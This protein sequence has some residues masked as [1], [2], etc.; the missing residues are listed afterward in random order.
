VCWG[1]GNPANVD[2]HAVVE[3][4]RGYGE[5]WI[6]DRETEQ[7]PSQDFYSGY[8]SWLPVDEHGRP[9]HPKILWEEAREQDSQTANT[10]MTF[11][12][13]VPYNGWLGTSHDDAPEELGETS[14][15]TCFV[16][17][18][19]VPTYGCVSPTF[20]IAVPKAHGHRPFKSNAPADTDQG[21]SLQS[22]NTT[23]VNTSSCMAQTGKRQK[24]RG[25]RGIAAAAFK[26]DI[27]DIVSQTKRSVQSTSGVRRCRVFEQA[28]E[29][30]LTLELLPVTSVSLAEVRCAIATSAR[31]ALFK[32]VAKCQGLVLLDPDGDSSESDVVACFAAGYVVASAS[33]RQHSMRLRLV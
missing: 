31:V 29:I 10:A 18:T 5:W 6:E 26:T 27:H 33:H 4:P 21:S 8:E 2:D 16:E 1:I 12:Q 19:P 15:W 28:T 23:S 3:Q 25:G 11:P 20:A 32:A 22:Q 30:T 24:N 7:A 14:K 17:D 13:T 9:G